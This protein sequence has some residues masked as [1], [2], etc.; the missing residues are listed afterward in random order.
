MLM[1]GIE[2]A[3][4]RLQRR[5]ASDRVPT[6]HGDVSGDKPLEDLAVRSHAAATVPRDA[7]GASR[8]TAR[9][10]PNVNITVDEVEDEDDDEDHFS[11]EANPPSRDGTNITSMVR[12]SP[13]VNITVDEVTDDDD[14]QDGDDSN[15]TPYSSGNTTSSDGTSSVG[16]VKYVEYVTD[17]HSLD[18]SPSVDF[19][20]Q[21]DTTV[22]HKVYTYSAPQPRQSH[23]NTVH[24]KTWYH[25]E[26]IEEVLSPIADTADLSSTFA[27]AFP[28]TTT[29]KWTATDSMHKHFPLLIIKSVEAGDD[30]RELPSLGGFVA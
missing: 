9:N 5:L 10:N 21:P 20:Q 1:A 30:M 7:N 3:R 22:Q 6:I 29:T 14:D 4:P 13:D 15:T 8:V 26:T 18:A 17:P 24:Q 25:L 27:H 12:N 23:R 2:R 11:S 19:V 16:S 28:M